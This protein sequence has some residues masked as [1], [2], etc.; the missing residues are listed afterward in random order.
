M[1]NI[2]GIDVNKILV[3]KKVSYGKNNS[4]KYFIEYND[5]DIIRPFFVKL[6]QTTSYINKL[7]DKK[8]K[9]TTT[10]MS[11]MVKDKQLFKNYNKLWEKIESLMRKKFDSKLFYGNDDNKYIKT[12]IK[13]FKDSIITNFHNKK[14]PEE[15]IPYKCLLIIALDSVIKTDNKYYPQTFLEECLYKQQKQKQQQKR[16][17]LLKN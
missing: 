4:F 6:P 17:I 16:I 10:T 3:S 14:V 7:R 12:K 13:T 1:F 9:I 11:L 15:K 5:N 2:N 8:T